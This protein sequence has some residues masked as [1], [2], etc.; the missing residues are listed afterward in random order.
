MPSDN[1]IKRV[2]ANP[3]LGLTSHLVFSILIVQIGSIYSIAL[4]LA[5]AIAPL[6]L[7]VRKEIRIIYRLSAWSFVFAG[8]GLFVLVTDFDQLRVFILAEVSLVLSLM[9][10]RLS[11]KVLIRKARKQQLVENRFYFHESFQVAF[12]TQYA[13]T[14]HLILILGFK[15]FFGVQYPLIERLVILN[16]FQFIVAIIIV[17][18]ALRLK[19]LAKRLQCEEWLPVISESGAVQGK[20]AKSVSISMKNKFLHPL[21]RVAIIHN[22]M[23]Y[24]KA[25]DESRLL[26]PGKLDY[27]IETYMRYQ[28]NIE[29][30]VS[31]AVKKEIKADMLTTRFI[32][33]YVFENECTKRLI[34]LYVLVITSEKTFNDLNLEGGKLWTANQIEDNVGSG[35]FS[36]TLELEYE[37]LKN[38]ILMT[39]LPLRKSK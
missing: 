38:T 20:V 16:L 34:F 39:D 28:Q 9:V 33:K 27:P 18:Q 29:E 17:Y 19:L 2:F 14:F 4:A 36:E 21:I 22:G 24:L 15:V 6:L 3:A 37:Y 23:L 31:K 13:L 1:F 32:L 25:R 8:L 5:F 7:G 11:R 35:I 10:F 12:I 26:D 30:A